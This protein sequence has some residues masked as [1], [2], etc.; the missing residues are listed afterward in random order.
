MST[1]VVALLQNFVCNIKY[2]NPLRKR[3][4]PFKR[5]NM[6]PQGEKGSLSFIFF[7]VEREGHHNS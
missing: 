3:S 4:T 2:S 6:T 7:G 5:Q 1:V